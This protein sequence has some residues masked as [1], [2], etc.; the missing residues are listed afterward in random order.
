MGKVDYG[1]NKAKLKIL[2]TIMDCNKLGYLPS[3]KCI[4]LVLKGIYEGTEFDEVITLGSLKSL[5]KKAC[6]IYISQL[7]R[8]GLVNE[9]YEPRLD[10]HY[11]YLS[12]EG[13]RIALESK[14]KF[15]K[16]PCPKNLVK[17]LF[18]SRK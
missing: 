4:L 3:Y 17:P 7:K 5:C 12:E 11:L 10:E 18:I 1:L 16:V 9:T 8:I 15:K 6:G 13:E 14:S 2:L